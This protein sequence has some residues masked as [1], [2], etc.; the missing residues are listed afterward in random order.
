MPQ[1]RAV[2]NAWLPPG[3]WVDPITL[4]REATTEFRGHMLVK[5]GMIHRLFSH[6]S[7]HVGRFD[8]AG[9]ELRH[10]Q[11][12]NSVDEATVPFVVWIEVWTKAAV[13]EW[14]DDVSKGS[15]HIKRE[16]FDQ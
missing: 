9:L 15:E 7:H 12:M 2:S 10:I 14:I 1:P 6:D 16:V 11:R 5:S 13:N 8:S 3:F 4:L